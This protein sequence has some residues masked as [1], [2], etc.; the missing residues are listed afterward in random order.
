MTNRTRRNVAGADDIAHAIHRMVDAM[1]PIATQPRAM[2]APICHVTMEDFMTHR[3]TKFSGKATPDE[4]NAS[5]RECEKICV[6]I[7]CTDAQKLSYV[8]FL[9]VAD[10]EYWWVGMQ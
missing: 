8:T 2:V 6:V 1:L 5:L 9:L 7:E 3:P 4:A 10:A